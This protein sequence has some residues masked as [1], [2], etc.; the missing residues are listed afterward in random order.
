MSK[1]L[2]HDRYL[3]LLVMDY[4]VFAP[5]TGGIF[6]YSWV[7][8]R[9]MD[10]FSKDTGGRGVRGAGR[11]AGGCVQAPY[12]CAWF[13][14]YKNNCN[15]IA[16]KCDSVIP[17]FRWFDLR[18]L[19]IALQHRIQKTST[20]IVIPHHENITCMRTVGDSNGFTG[21]HG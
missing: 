5:K 21:N 2:G 16:G 4:M 1:K 3:V 7:T 14:Y 20:E 13:T 18:P 11:E 12:I 9:V 6:S 15:K 17:L 10:A 19:K 8:W